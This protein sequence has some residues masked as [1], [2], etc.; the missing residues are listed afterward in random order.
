[1]LIKGLTLIKNG[2][3][4]KNKVLNRAIFELIRPTLRNFYL[5]LGARQWF[6]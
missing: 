3:K 6:E 2:C 5:D 1:M 4:N